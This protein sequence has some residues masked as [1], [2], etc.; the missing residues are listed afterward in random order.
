MR[1]RTRFFLAGCVVMTLAMTPT[2]LTQGQ[3]SGLAS[4]Y[5]VDP[6]LAASADAAVVDAF[7]LAEVER[8]AHRR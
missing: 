7:A 3:S 8:L 2:S 6:M 4:P 1:I 5:H